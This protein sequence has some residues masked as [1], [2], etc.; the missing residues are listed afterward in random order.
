M[1][2]ICSRKPGA[3]GLMPSSAKD[4]ERARTILCMSPKHVNLVDEGLDLAIRIGVLEDSPLIVR[5]LAPSRLVF[6]ASPA[7]LA[8]HGTPR[9]PGE[10][11]RHNCLRVNL[12]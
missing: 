11:A 12:L 1:N 9:E 6:C 4:G 3:Q 5:K 7:Y 8:A 2:T 10:L